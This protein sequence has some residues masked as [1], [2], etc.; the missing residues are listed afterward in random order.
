MNAV[1]IALKAGELEQAI[2]LYEQ[3]LF[4]MGDI[5]DRHGVAAVSMGLGMAVHFRG[6]CEK[7]Q[8]LLTEAQT[9][10]REGVGGQGLSWPLS[11]VMVDTHTHDLLLQATRRY[12]SSLS[13]PPDDWGRMVIAEARPSEGESG[14]N[15]REQKRSGYAQEF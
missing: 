11:N 14:L 12:E 13:L 2:E 10:F 9:N 6:E 4:L 1:W 3:S 8:P 5:G 15:F 7:V